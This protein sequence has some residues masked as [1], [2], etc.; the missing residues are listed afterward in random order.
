MGSAAPGTPEEVHTRAVQTV[1]DYAEAAVVKKIEKSDALSEEGKAKLKA[2]VAK[3]KSEILAK[4]EE[5]R[6]KTKT[7]DA[8]K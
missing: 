1:S 2:E 6:A 5:I 4:I 7:G 8:E 3:L